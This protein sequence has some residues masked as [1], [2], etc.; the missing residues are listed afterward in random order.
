MIIEYIFLFIFVCCFTC[1]CVF[2]YCLKR[3]LRQFYK[4][5]VLFILGMFTHIATS[6]HIWPDLSIYGLEICFV[7]L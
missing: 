4:F 7:F 3:D 1:L 6:I 5:K 2:M